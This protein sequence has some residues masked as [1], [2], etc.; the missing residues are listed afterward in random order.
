MRLTDVRKILRESLINPRKAGPHKIVV[1]MGSPSYWETRAI[2]L[3]MEAQAGIAG[4]PRYH[5][6]LKLAITMLALARTEHADIAA[7]A[8]IANEAGDNTSK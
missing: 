5:E 8:I 6:N 3:I 1:D 4:C 7:K 2:E